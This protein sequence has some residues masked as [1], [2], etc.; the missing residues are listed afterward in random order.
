M[1]S[2]AAAVIPAAGTGRR[3]GGARKPFLEVAGAPL[4]WH[5]L[6]PF[7]AIAEIEWIIV[8]LH[9]DEVG[10]PPPWLASLD[11]RVRLVVGGAERGESVLAGLRVVPAEAAVVAIHD[12]ARPLATVDL[13]RRVLAA[14]SRGYGALAALPLVDTIHE[15]DAESTIVATPRRERFRRAQTPQAFP[16]DLILAAYEQA[17]AAGISATDDAALVARFGGRVVT[18]AGEEQNIKVTTAADLIIAE[19]FLR[20]RTT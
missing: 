5:T 8:A 12:A 9:R 2:R 19:A 16:R 17:V 15:V 6:R 11:R 1:G 18:V 14:A 3:I 20:R 13:V 4:L 10:R 7:L